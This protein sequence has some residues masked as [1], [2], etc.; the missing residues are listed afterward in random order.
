MN[1][2]I[3]IFLLI[4]LLSFP[5]AHATLNNDVKGYFGFNE[6]S[7]TNA[8]D[9]ANRYNG[10]I[11]SATYSSNKVAGNYSLNFGTT[12]NN[13]F[14]SINP[15]ALSEF[16]T[17]STD[18]W[19]I[20]FWVNSTTDNTWQRIAEYGGTTSANNFF[21]QKPGTTQG[22]DNE[23][24]HYGL[25]N[26]LAT[27][28]AKSGSGNT[29]PTN[30]WVM[31]T[32]V[33]NGTHTILYMNGEQVGT[34]ATITNRTFGAGFTRWYIGRRADATS[35]NFAGLIDELIYYDRILNSTEINNL[36]TRQL[37]GE[38]YPFTIPEPEPTLI[39]VT[40]ESRDDTTNDRISSSL[41]INGISQGTI[42][43]ISTLTINN[44]N[45]SNLFNF[46]F[47]NLS[48]SY[49]TKEYFNVN[50]SNTT[51]FTG[52]LSPVPIG[53]VND[54]KEIIFSLYDNTNSVSLSGFYYDFNGTLYFSSGTSQSKILNSSLLYNVS[55]SKSGYDPVDYE[56]VNISEISVITGFTDPV[57]V[58]VSNVTFTAISDTNS[59]ISGFSVSLNDGEFF[60][61]ATG[62]ELLLSIPDD[63][64]YN[65]LFNISYSKFGYYTN[66]YDNVNLSTL[67]HEGTL[68]AKT[69][70]GDES[71][72]DK[73]VIWIILALVGGI[74]VS[75]IFARPM[76]IVFG[77]SIMFL[78]YFL[79]GNIMIEYYWFAPVGYVLGAVI[80]LTGMLRLGFGEK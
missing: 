70:V 44:M 29:I 11:T 25:L 65:L 71:L 61:T 74:G 5:L 46:T 62:T 22:M 73:A 57:I 18:V 72:D 3:I 56:D 16:L 60:G 55:F 37:A 4:F 6:G 79:N 12:S 19:T 38:T 66:S 20:S 15:L 13:Y 69:Y 23:F 41:S 80:I 9:G 32:S 48:A 53:P 35:E 40:F 34:P 78:T 26:N 2:N 77:F 47:A 52:Y 24:R 27:F 28:D 31:L 51:L 1:K 68:V 14:V 42:T 43:S 8:I 58:N 33:G 39:N 54:T 67:S 10:T 76:L 7:G 50:I 17:Y 45:Y 75:A 64:L 30:T 36:Y 49:V 63:I 21:F 59:T